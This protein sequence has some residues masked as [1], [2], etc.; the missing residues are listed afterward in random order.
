MAGAWFEMGVGVEVG[1]GGAPGI[2]G[3]VRDE[4]MAQA[5]TARRSGTTPTKRAKGTRKADLDGL[6]DA[7]RIERCG[8]RSSAG[9]GG[10][11]SGED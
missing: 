6:S 8:V 1:V 2:G 9:N 3:A 5:S 10:R 11:A 4:H 7:H